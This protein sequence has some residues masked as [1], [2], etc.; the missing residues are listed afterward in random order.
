M[1]GEQFKGMQLLTGLEKWAFRS[2]RMELLMKPCHFLE[3]K[4]RPKD[5][6]EYYV[7]KIFE[8]YVFGSN[9]GN[10]ATE[11]VSQFLRCQFCL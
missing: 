7:S 4:P 11:A 1:S 8:G 10:F 6:T 2:I 3:K 5:R 9:A